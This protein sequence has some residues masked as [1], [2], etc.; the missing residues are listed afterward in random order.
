MLRPSRTLLAATGLVGL[1]TL[2]GCDNPRVSIDGH[3][4]VPLDRLQLA[5]LSAS[6]V[7]LLGPD[8]VHIVPGDTLTIH[9]DGDPRA[10]AALRFVLKDG[11]LGIGRQPDANVGPGTATVTISDPAVDHLVLAG[12]GTILSDRLHGAAVGVT[13]GGSGRV[14]ATQVAAQQFDVEVL[15]SGSFSGSGHA[16]KLS[17]TLAGSG[18]ADMAGLDAGEAQIDLAGTG[19][20]SLASNG[21]VSGTV[22]GTGVVTVHGRAQCDVSVTGPGR[23]TCQP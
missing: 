4:G 19:T 11:K 15:G 1:L 7:T 2:A 18:T 10:V 12:S 3:T 21:R 14:V 17:L 20:G 5:G 16:D 8:T 9:A 6:E 22:A 23:V 13:I